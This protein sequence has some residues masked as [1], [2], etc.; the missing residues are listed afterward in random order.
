MASRLAEDCIYTC[1]GLPARVRVGSHSGRV[2]VARPL[3]GT[4]RLFAIPVVVSQHRLL[5]S[6]VARSVSMLVFTGRLPAIAVFAMP[7]PCAL[8]NRSGKGDRGREAAEFTWSFLRQ[9]LF[10]IWCPSGELV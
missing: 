2:L 3:L 4:I 5:D 9:Y 6:P 8:D 10:Y 7:V 1:R